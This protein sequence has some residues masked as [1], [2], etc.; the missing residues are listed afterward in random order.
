VYHT[1]MKM[2]RRVTAFTDKFP[3]I[4]PLVWALSVQYFVVQFIAARAWHTPF[5]LSRNVISDLGNTACGQYA[6]RYVCS[7]QHGLMNASFILL[8]LTMALGSLLIYQEFVRSRA[9]LVGFSLMAVSG[10]G[11]LLVGLFPEN[12]IKLL[13]A[14]G[15]SL[16]F[17]LGNLSMVVLAL[18][19]QRVRPSFRVYT[20]I[21]G[22]VAL[23]AFV[24]FASH[25]YLGLGQ[26]G[27]ERLVSYPQTLWL[28]LFGLYMSATRLRASKSSPSSRRPSRHRRHQ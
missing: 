15:A 7:P 11:T 9:S 2:H 13:H 10:A 17:G 18:A 12:T 20:F 5:S 24:L 4:G 16:T 21:S 14:L 27:M 1:G 23:T 8:G 22:V 6:Q 26:G 28:T 19:L 25:H 3:L